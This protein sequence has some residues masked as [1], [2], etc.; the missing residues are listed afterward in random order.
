MQ[1]VLADKRQHF[2]LSNNCKTLH[3]LTQRV[4]KDFQLKRTTLKRTSIKK[5]IVRVNDWKSLA[6]KIDK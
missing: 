3:S 6:K 2:I 1:V 5:Y 4:L